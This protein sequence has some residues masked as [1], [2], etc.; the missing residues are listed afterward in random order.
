MR[1]KL[2]G[3]WPYGHTQLDRLYALGMDSYAIIPYLNRIS[4]ENAVR[5]NGVT[6][7]LSLDNDGRLHRQLLW[8]RFKRGVPR[9]IDTFYNY[10]GQFEI[11]NG[12][13]SRR[14]S[15]PRS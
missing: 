15:R 7:G 13:R 4:S 5:F 8:A 3:E 14:S 9:L 11:E 12:A 1:E 2:Q 6:S 10:K